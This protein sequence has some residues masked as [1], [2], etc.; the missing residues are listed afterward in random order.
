MWLDIIDRRH[1]VEA[2]AVLLEFDGQRDVAGRGL[3]TGIGNSPPAMKLA[4]CPT[5]VRFGWPGS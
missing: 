3:A 5:V 1:E 2:D 4:G